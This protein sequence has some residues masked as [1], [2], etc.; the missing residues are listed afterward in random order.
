MKKYHETKGPDGKPV[1]FPWDAHTYH[2]SSLDN[3][4][5]QWHS[6]QSVFELMDASANEMH[7][8]YRYTQVGMF[9]SDVMFLT[10]LDIIAALDSQ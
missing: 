10:P 9:R 8:T 5:E 7:A 4:F 6:I 2:K 1:Y 3:I